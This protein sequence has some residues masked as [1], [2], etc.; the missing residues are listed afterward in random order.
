M[1]SCQKSLMLVGKVTFDLARLCLGYSFTV[2]DCTSIICHCF[3][4][5]YILN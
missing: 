3:G 5:C 2:D 4:I 1:E